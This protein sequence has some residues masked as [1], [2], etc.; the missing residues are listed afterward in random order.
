MNFNDAVAF[1]SRY[2]N[3]ERQLRYPYDG[4]A[5]NL[6]RMAAL[7]EGLGRPDRRLKIIQV[8]G[9]K[10]KGS[11]AAMIAAMLTASG[12]RVGLYTSP[13]LV[14]FRERVRIDGAMASEATI[15]AGV[16]RLIPAAE[17]AERRPELGPLTYF[18][19]LT[20]L[21]LE[22]FA[23]TGCEAA[24]LEAGL[25][26]RYDATTACDPVV[27]VLTPISYDHT[28]ILGETLA[29][30]AGEK[31]MI[32][33]GP[34]PAVLA[35]QP[36]E[37]RAVLLDRCR[38]VGAPAVRVE[39]EYRWTRREESPDGQNFDLTGRR[40]LA[41]LLLPLSGEHQLV[42]AAAAVAAVDASA[43]AGLGVPD[44]AV[45][46]GL[47]SVRWPARFQRVRRSPDVVLDGAHNAASAAFLRDT[48]QRLY[49]GRRVTAVVGLGADKDV[50]GFGRELAPCLSRLIITRS[51]AMKAAE[52][53]RVRAAFAGAGL[54]V[55]EAPE[56]SGALETALAGAG[57]DEVVVVTGSFY[58][59]SEAMAALGI[60]AA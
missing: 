22:G 38:A 9:T 35:P 34:A 55:V 12:R 32:V 50:E 27:A 19:L 23:A 51:K 56:V 5:M 1:L 45:R 29:A 17:S 43:S 48:I 30:I 31:A 24:V 53:A 59:V 25:G 33:K 10:G 8:A 20:A 6:E 47:A 49:S 28:D 40:E 14:D 18:E 36:D 52:V 15:A 3:Y 4:W 21:A 57:P 16:A 7:L 42:N 46:A 37:A 58:V 26:G 60:P 41:G 2:T 44:A 13:H 11:T 39:E 54:D